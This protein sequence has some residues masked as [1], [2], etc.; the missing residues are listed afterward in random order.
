[1]N[2]TQLFVYSRK[3]GKMRFFFFITFIITYFTTYAQDVR[4]SLHELHWSGGQCCNRGVNYTLTLIIED[5]VWMN[6]DSLTICGPMGE[7][8]FAQ[9][10]L[11]PAVY[12]NQVQLSLKFQT[13]SQSLQPAFFVNKKTE[14]ICEEWDIKMY[15]GTFSKQVY[16]TSKTMDMAAY[17]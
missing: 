3:I 16:I 11:S 6:M 10:Q 13:Y 9:N 7:K 4:A 1:M 14:K 17:P 2:H 5:M 12:N 15:N 8:S